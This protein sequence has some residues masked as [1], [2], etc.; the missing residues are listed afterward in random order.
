MDLVA[1]ESLF[2]SKLFLGTRDAN[3]KLQ[4]Q[5][6]RVELLRCYWP[7]HVCYTL[8]LSSRSTWM[9]KV[10]V[11]FVY[12][13]HKLNRCD[14]HHSSYG[15]RLLSRYALEVRA[16]DHA[17]QIVMGNH[18]TFGDKVVVISGDFRQILLIVPRGT[19]LQVLKQCIRRSMLW[20][21][22]RAYRLR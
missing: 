18:R 11:T 10:P 16:L 6:F 8:Q 21:K 12:S 3:R 1:P 5:W 14:R 9:L 4:S 13:Q 2:Y 19:F 22:F 20:G 7:A 15:K 17:L